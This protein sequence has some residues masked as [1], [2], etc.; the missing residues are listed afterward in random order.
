MRCVCDGM[1]WLGMAMDAN[2]NAAGAPRISRPDSAVSTWVI[3]T[4]EDAMIMRHRR[5]LLECRA[6]R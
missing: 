6:H 5:R 3:R 2:A 4:D 1:A